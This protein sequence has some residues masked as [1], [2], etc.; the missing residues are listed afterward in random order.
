MFTGNWKSAS[1]FRKTSQCHNSAGCGNP[2][3]SICGFPAHA[4]HILAAR[5]SSSVPRAPAAAEMRAAEMLVGRKM[6]DPG[7][8]V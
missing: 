8:V 7:I 5:R 2:G 6:P 4:L 3:D 1:A